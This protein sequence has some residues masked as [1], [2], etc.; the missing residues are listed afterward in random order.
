MNKEIKAVQLSIAKKK[1]IIS[2]H[3]KDIRRLEKDLKILELEEKVAALSK[4]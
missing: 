3:Q 1:N 4:K 2:N